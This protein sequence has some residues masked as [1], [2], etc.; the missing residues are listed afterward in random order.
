MKVTIE[1]H[2]NRLRLRWH[3]GTKRQTLALGL[4]DSPACRSKANMVKNQIELDWQIGQYD[5]T[6]LKYRPR[7][8]GKNATELLAP[9]LFARWTQYQAKEKKLARS[10]I[11]AKYQPIERAL[12]KELNMVAD[13]ITKKTAGKLVD[14]WVENV[15]PDVGR[16]RIWLLTSCWDWAVDRYR[17][18]AENPWKGMG[19]RF[20]EQPKRNVDPFDADEVR[21]ILSGFRSHPESNHYA[22]FVALLLAIGCRT[23][24]AIGL[25]W[26]SISKDFTII[27]ICE[28][29]N[30]GVVG[31][32]KTKE[33]RAVPVPPSLA[34]IL[35]ARKE[36][37]QPNPDDLVFTTRQGQTI[38]RDNFRSRHWAKVLKAAGVRYRRTYE[39]RAT[40]ASH[41][42]SNG[43][44]YL[45][46]AKALGH[47]P[48]VMHD[49]YSAAMNQDCPFVDFEVVE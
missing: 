45:T 8:T 43:G 40:V 9:E 22:D 47:N 25:R 2:Q 15:S 32:T 48:N 35:K 14:L 3:D 1:N 36:R 26:R 10:T 23:G 49:K 16:Q 46:I 11:V 38:D 7:T 39:T 12:A 28:S 34:A 24:E 31:S 21:A 33:S 18:A 6:L 27:H 41:A 29:I 44:N 5:Q 4:T 13:A 17:I 20:G 42:L 19:S 37:Y 30:K